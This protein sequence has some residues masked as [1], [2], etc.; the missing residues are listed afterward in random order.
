MEENLLSQTQAVDFSLIAL[1]VRAT[2]TVQ[3][4]MLILVAS[5]FWSW[6]IIIQKTIDYRRAKN[7]KKL[8]L[9]EFCFC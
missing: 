6:S 3:I 1:F 4:V 2:I 7:E 8:F 5:S 9:D